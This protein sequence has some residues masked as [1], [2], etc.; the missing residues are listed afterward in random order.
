MN[1]TQKITVLTMAVFAAVMFA[2]PV[3]MNFGDN[4][5]FASEHHDHHDHHHHHHHHEHHHHHH[6]HHDHH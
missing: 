3:A 4:L 1:K 2:A 6:E 5:A